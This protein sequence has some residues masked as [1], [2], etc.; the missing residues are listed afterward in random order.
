MVPYLAWESLGARSRDNERSAA[1][2]TFRNLLT[3]P[4]PAT[5]YL[6][7]FVVFRP[8]TR[9]ALSLFALECSR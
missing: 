9:P 7:F 1:A 2:V 4:I 8:R 5:S 6:V 3:Y